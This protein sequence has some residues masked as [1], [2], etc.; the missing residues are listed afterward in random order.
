MHY[1]FLIIIIGL[2]GWVVSLGGLSGLGGANTP[3][4]DT[5]E[6]VDI[7]AP[8][9]AARDVVNQIESRSSGSIN[10][11]NQ[12]LTRVPSYVFDRTEAT[13]LD[14]SHN[15][16]DG[17]LQAEVRHLKNLRTLDLSHNT[18]TGVPAEVGQLTQLETL[19]LSYNPITGLPHEIGSLKN[20]K[21]LDVRGTEYSTF[22]LDIIRK[23][24]PQTTN[25]I[26]E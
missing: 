13:S 4:D 26:T 3:V 5:E 23:A 1:I 20:L 19:D 6:I 7:T 12:G 11:S 9:D 22:D 17:A 10:L 25:I 16:L 14:V 2:I 24:L 15:T 8:I 18:F 21:T